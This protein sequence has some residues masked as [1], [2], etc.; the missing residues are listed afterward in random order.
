MYI[1]AV[2]SLCV[3]KFLL[4]NRLKPFCKIAKWILIHGDWNVWFKYE[5]LDLHCQTIH[6]G[7]MDDD[8]DDESL[9]SL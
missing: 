5:M 7:W 6:N 1:S 4:L 2:L 8:D 9:T 3:C